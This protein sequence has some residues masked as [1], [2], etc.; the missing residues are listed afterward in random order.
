MESPAISEDRQSMEEASRRCCFCNKGFRSL[1]ALGGHQTIHRREI[2][3]MRRQHDAYMS[4][5]RRSGRPAFEPRP[6]SEGA[7]VGDEDRLR[8][9]LL[10]ANAAFWAA[11]RKLRREPKPHDFFPASEGWASV[12]D[13]IVGKVEPRRLGRDEGGV[14]LDLKL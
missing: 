10:G 2:K 5:S 3:E 1:Q 9:I 7:A 14:D 12:S 4:A 8:M 6:S 13:G 11:H